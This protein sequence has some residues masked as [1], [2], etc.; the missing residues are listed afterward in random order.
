MIPPVLP[1]YELQVVVVPVYADKSL[2]LA[3]AVTCW[4]ILCYG[5][6]CPTKIWS[7]DAIF[8]EMRA[9]LFGRGQLEETA[10]GFWF[11]NTE[12]VRADVPEGW[13][14]MLNDKHPDDPKYNG[15]Y[16]VK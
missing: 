4:N 9:M 16:Q 13:V 8:D 10:A 2:T 6:I 7:C 12:W 3:A 14:F 15:C 11:L 1:G 5:S